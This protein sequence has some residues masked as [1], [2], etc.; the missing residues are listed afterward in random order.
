MLKRIF[1]LFWHSQTLLGQLHITFAFPSPPICILWIHKQLTWSP[2][3]F[4]L[5]FFNSINYFLKIQYQ[6]IRKTRLNSI[7]KLRLWLIP[8]SMEPTGFTSQLALSVCLSLPPLH[9]PCT[10]SKSKAREACCRAAKFLAHTQQQRDT[11]QRPKTSRK[12]YV[13][14]YHKPW[15]ETWVLTYSAPT[16]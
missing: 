11:A 10:L 7:P 9:L 6:S 5:L 8:N 2:M 16:P 4:L 15:Q 12:L 1:P 13:Q 3:V 14:V